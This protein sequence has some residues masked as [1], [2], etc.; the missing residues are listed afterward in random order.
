MS[1][2]F[3]KRHGILCLEVTNDEVVVACMQPFV[4]GWEPQLEHVA[5]RQVKRVLANPADIERHTVEFYTLARSVNRARG[6]PAG[7]GTGNI[8]PM[9]GLGSFSGDPEAHDMYILYA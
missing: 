5:R 4:T 2:A 8:G 1:Y 6:G 3:A 7:C 9:V